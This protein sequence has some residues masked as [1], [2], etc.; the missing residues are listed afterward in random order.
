VIREFVAA[1]FYDGLA[2]PYFAI[3]GKPVVVGMLA[4]NNIPRNDNPV[5]VLCQWSQLR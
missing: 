4:G 1:D 2:K 3:L 5:V